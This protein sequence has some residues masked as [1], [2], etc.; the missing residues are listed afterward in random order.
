[1]SY[2]TQQ[3]PSNK[4]E[5]KKNTPTKTKEKQIRLMA[6]QYWQHNVTKKTKKKRAERN[7][8]KGKK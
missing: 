6:T 1:M 2:L 7:E 8:L 3:C 4:S 5:K